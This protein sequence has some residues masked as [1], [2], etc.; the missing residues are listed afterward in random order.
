MK[1]MV[2]ILQ[3]T[4]VN[5]ATD[6]WTDG[7]TNIHTDGQSLKLSPPFLYAMGDNYTFYNAHV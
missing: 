1:L 6:G 3:E 7:R 5:V 2:L 4:N